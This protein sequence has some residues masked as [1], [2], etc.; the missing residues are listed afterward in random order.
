MTRRKLLAALAALPAASLLPR[1][2]LAADASGLEQAME[3]GLAFLQKQQKA[4]GSFDGIGPP[5]ALAG[6]ALLAFLA[7]GH[8]PELGRFG[9]TVRNAVDYLVN[10]KPEK[11]YFGRDGGKMYGHAIVTLALS[12]VF[13]AE[14]SPAQ[15]RKVRA[16]LDGAVGV[17][18]DAQDVK[19]QRRAHQGG[20]RYEPESTDADLSVTGWCLMALRGAQNAGLDIPRQRVDSAM[21]F[22]ANCYR[23]DKAAF[24]YSPDE[25]PSTAMTAVGLTALHLI[26][27]TQ[28]I[29]PRGPAEY[30]LRHPVREGQQY[31]YYAHYYATQAAFAAGDR[32]WDLVWKNTASQLLPMQRKE[33]GSWPRKEDPGGDDRRGRVYSTAMASLTLA[34]PLRL[35]PMYQR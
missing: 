9:L 21:N 22:L 18:A 4:D 7:S 35:L 34:V 12:E 5:A 6:L 15:R 3:R 10:L 29:D 8:V 1:A 32:T 25:D 11:S 30:L 19:R 33:D 24:C 20:W 26:G 31:F 13:G 2:S 27:Q 17:L 28:R 23:A 14:S 16:A